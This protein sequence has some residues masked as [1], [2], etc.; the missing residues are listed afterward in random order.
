MYAVIKNGGKQYRVQEGDIILLDKMS[1]EPKT[2]VEFNEV[3]MIGGES[4]KIGTPFVAGAV[5]KGEVINEGRARK[6]ITFKKRRRK[7]SKTK[8]GFRRDFTRVRIV[9]IAA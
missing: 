1:L 2:A 4:P 7:D 6:V 5:V 9:S 3:L 8:R